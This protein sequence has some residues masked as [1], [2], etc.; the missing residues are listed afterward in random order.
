MNENEEKKENNPNEIILHD[1]G[2]IA[3]LRYLKHNPLKIELSSR[4]VYFHFAKTPEIQ[5]IVEK[6][7]IGLTMEIEPFRLI[8]NFRNTKAITFRAL[9]ARRREHGDKDDFYDK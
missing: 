7:E 5:K 4:I 3:L 1:I 8:E 2:I 6:Y 9:D